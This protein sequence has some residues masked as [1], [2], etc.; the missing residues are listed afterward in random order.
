MAIC[1]QEA[2]KTIADAIGEVREAADFCRYYA[3][4]ARNLHPVDLPGPTGERNTLHIEGR[5]LGDGRAV[6]FPAGDLPG[7]TVA[8]LVT[9]DTVVAQPAPQTPGSRACGRACACGRGA[10]RCAGARDRRAGGRRGA[11][12]GRAGRGRRVHRIDRDR[13]SGSRGR[14][15]DDDR[16]DRAADRGDR[17][18][19]RD[20]R[21]L[22]PRLPSRWWRT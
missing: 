16:A 4:E 9:G 12:R 11:D 14:W 19:Q 22:P 1:V 21:R 18:D 3:A 10:G 5:E 2:F 17:R 20:D 7:Q 15:S 8:A 6:E 13:G